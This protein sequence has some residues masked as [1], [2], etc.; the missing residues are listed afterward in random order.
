MGIYLSKM[1]HTKIRTIQYILIATQVIFLAIAVIFVYY[2]LQNNPTLESMKIAAIVGLILILPIF[3]TGLLS[4]IQ[5]KK[6]WKK[7]L[8]IFIWLFYFLSIPYF[9]VKIWSGYNFYTEL[10]PYKKT[11]VFVNG[12][13]SSIEKPIEINYGEQIKIDWTSTADFCYFSRGWYDLLFNLRNTDNQN[14]YFDFSKTYSSSGKL[15]L[16]SQ[17]ELIQKKINQSLDSSVHPKLQNQVKVDFYLNCHHKILGIPIYQK[18]DTDYGLV[19]IH[20]K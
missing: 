18:N 6:R 4:I 19:I 20:G 5:I 10:L 7:S 3:I 15:I 11:K 12:Q 14:K 13:K 8:L 16:D 2:F 9:E 1:E 17:S